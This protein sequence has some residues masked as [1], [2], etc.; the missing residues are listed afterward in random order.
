MKN[1]KLFVILTTNF[2]YDN[3]EIEFSESLVSGIVSF[4]I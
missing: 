2:L 3:F 4:K 1:T